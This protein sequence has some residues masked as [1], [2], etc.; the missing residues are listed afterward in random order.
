[1]INCKSRTLHLT[2]ALIY[3][4]FWILSL[5]T[6]SAQ[7]M[8]F[9]PPDVYHFSVE[10]EIS[11]H[12]QQ[13]NNGFNRK[14]VLSSELEKVGL[15]GSSV[16]GDISYSKFIQKIRL[17]YGLNEEFNFGITIPL[18]KR[19]RNSQ[20]QISDSSATSFV[21]NNASVT[22]EGL[23]DVEIWGLWRLYYTDGFDFQLGLN[24][25]GSNGTFSYDDSNSLSTGDGTE[26]LS[27][28]FRWYIYSKK[29]TIHGIIEA[30]GEVAN[31]ATIR[32][33][34]NEEVEMAPGN[35]S[36]LTMSIAGNID[37]FQIGGGVQLD[38][39]VNTQIGDTSMGDGYMG[40]TI[41]SYINYGNLQ[42]LE[43]EQPRHL[44]EVQLNLK[45]V[46]FGDNI[47]IENT[48]GFQASYYF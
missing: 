21:G 14:S 7:T 40:Y 22:S 46:I 24:L 12:D 16:S 11:Y 43:T 48:I 44:W 35:K 30:A 39:Q 19:E 2:I 8:S 23:G 28:F 15:D 13:F 25:E 36:Q 6:L 41:K 4:F 20:L 38:S 10:S 29:S 18:I 17:Q 32:D 3:L 34:T 33:S 37:R 47:P 9:L 1:M 42:L 26:N 31:Y 45:A 27:F 5:S